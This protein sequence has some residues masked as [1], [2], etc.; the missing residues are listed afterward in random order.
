MS[1]AEDRAGE[2]RASA[3]VSVSSAGV[4]RYGSSGVF[5]G[6]PSFEA[7]RAALPAELAAALET[8]RL[9]RQ[10]VVE[11]APP[12]GGPPRCFRFT[13]LHAEGPGDGAAVAIDALDGLDDAA[14]ALREREARLRAVLDVHDDNVWS[15]DTDY[16]LTAFNR[17]FAEAFVK[18]MGRGPRVGACVIDYARTPFLAGVWQEFYDRALAGEQVRTELD[19]PVL[20]RAGPMALSMRPIVHDGRVSGAACFLR[21]LTAVR[22]QSRAVQ[23]QNHL[24]DALARVQSRFI[25]EGQS[26]DIYG[27][28]LEALLSLT[29]SPAGFLGELERAPTD[30]PGL[31]LMAVQRPPDGSRPPRVLPVADLDPLTARVL[32]TG[33]PVFADPERAGPPLEATP[34][35]PVEP[36]HFLGLPCTAGG[37]LIGVIGLAGRPDGYDRAIVTF[38]QPLLQAF[39]NI[40]EARRAEL[41][42]LE[43]EQAL[44]RAKEAAE[45]ADRAKGDFL[46]SMSHEIRTP[47][48]AVLGLCELALDAAVDADQKSLLR[49]ARS[50]SETLLNL[51]SDILDFS[52]IDAGRIELDHAPF[53]LRRL[54]ED[55]AETAAVR[56]EPKGIAVVAAV[57]P[58]LPSPLVGDVHRVRQVLTNL[59]SNAV[60]YTE[61]GEVVIEVSCAPDSERQRVR[62]DVVDTG[63]GIPP[64]EHERIFE[65]FHRVAAT[66]DVGGGG[67]GL[68]LSITRF[69]VEHMGGRIELWSEVGRGSRFRVEL[70]FDV[71]VDTVDDGPVPW[72][73]DD[74]RAVLVHPGNSH[75]ELIPRMLEAYGARVTVVASPAAALAAEADVVLSRVPVPNSV[76]PVVRLAPVAELGRPHTAGQRLT[77]PLRRDALIDA[78]IAAVGLD[79]GF[80]RSPSLHPLPPVGHCAV[81]LVEDHPDNR[82]VARRRLESRGHQV[83][84]AEHGGLAIEAAREVAYDIILMDLHMPEVDGFAAVERIRSDEARLG[85]RP[86]PIVAVTA[87]ATADVRRRCFEVGFDGFVP[88][89]VSGSSL[90]EAVERFA[91]SDPIALIVDDAADS[92]R[93]LVRHLRRSVPMRLR[94][95]EDGASAR[96]VVDRTPPTVVLVDATLPDESGFDLAGWMR[97]MIGPAVTIIMVTGRIDAEARQRAVDAGC[98]GYVTKP[99]DRSALLSAIDAGRRGGA[100]RVGPRSTSGPGLLAAPEEAPTTEPSAPLP[101][102]PGELPQRP[103]AH[104][105]PDLLDLIPPFLQDRRNDLETIDASLDAGDLTTVARLGHSMKGTGRAYGMSAVSALGQRI[106]QAA[107]G[108]DVE[109]VR[110]VC[111]ELADYVETVD[112]RAES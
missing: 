55:V 12:G 111:A 6:W 103:L 95:A 102:L 85:I 52:R 96:A 44:Q 91:S 48:N 93:L 25:G 17:S 109:R 104:V 112:V 101:P 79:R 64:G 84:T 58:R 65:R 97:D 19:K 88:K 46:A 30:P 106:E 15:V 86:T 61:E 100:R 99:V 8:G 51:I 23:K 26:A 49:A 69:L 72:T 39:G 76:V 14:V 1:R 24:L 40:L 68:G 89:P 33:H 34:L 90:Q 4:R 110:A 56:A 108:G 50:N 67:T 92:R 28:L 98:D 70:P 3:F 43:A 107:R 38:L 75:A 80:Q 27:E 105:A 11:V 22:S 74:V 59:A 10:V 82:A 13:P 16:R 94:I 20:H 45:H 66:A 37:R 36:G 63:Y 2:T 35:G 9:T 29:D 32:E 5:E 60:K 77:L 53:D 73:L 83:D 42:R 21:D 7:W 18:S 57:Q 47:L 78:I 62:I 31:M 54:V 41:R 81:L 87:H 71:A